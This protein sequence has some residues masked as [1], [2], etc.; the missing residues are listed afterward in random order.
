MVEKSDSKNGRVNAASDVKGQ[1]KL[2]AGSTRFERKT[3][4][5]LRWFIRAIKCS[6]FSFVFKQTFYETAAIDEVE[7]IKVLYC[8]FR[9]FMVHIKTFFVVACWQI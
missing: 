8:V 4:T 3:K 7:M 6:F 2:S 9:D 5:H 1:K